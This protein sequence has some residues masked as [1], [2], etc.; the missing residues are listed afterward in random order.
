MIMLT[1]VL[2]NETA[3]IHVRNAAG[4]ALKNALSARVRPSFTT[5]PSLSSTTHRTFK[6]YRTRQDNKIT[7]IDGFSS[8]PKQ[9]TASNN[10]RS[11]LSHPPHKK[12]AILLHRSSPPSPPSNSPTINGLI[13][14]NSSSASSTIKKTQ[15]SK[16]RPSRLSVLSVK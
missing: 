1:S 5:P 3:Q 14:S 7:L 13:S 11:R 2:A 9:R 10:R 6:L 16:S 12:Q 4:L 8:T 15:I